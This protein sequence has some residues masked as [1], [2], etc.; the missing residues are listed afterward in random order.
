MHYCACS[1]FGLLERSTVTST[2]K[3]RTKRKQQDLVEP[4]R[5]KR[6]ANIKTSDT[7]L[8]TKAATSESTAETTSSAAT[9]VEQMKNKFVTASLLQ[10]SKK[11]EAMESDLFKKDEDFQKMKAAYEQEKL[12]N[13]IIIAEKKV[14]ESR[15]NEIELKLMLKNQEY[16]EL[17]KSKKSDDNTNTKSIGIQITEKEP[18]TTIAVGVEETIA[19]SSSAAI[20]SSMSATTSVTSATKSATKS[21]TAEETPLDLSKRIYN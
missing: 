8:A 4:R 2:V 14:V 6:I 10:L 21:V 20:I 1:K 12:K 7:T 13:D 17:L 16:D 15:F 5:S 11:V 18:S 19:T 9:S 3:R